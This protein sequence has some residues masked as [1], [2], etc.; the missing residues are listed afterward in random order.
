MNSA[1]IKWLLLAHENRS[2]ACSPPR[3]EARGDT[4]GAGGQRSS[5]GKAAET[6]EEPEEECDEENRDGDSLSKAAAPPMESWD[7]AA[8]DEVAIRVATAVSEQLRRDF[9][10]AVQA[11]LASFRRR[12]CI[13]RCPRR[14]DS[15]RANAAVSSARGSSSSSSSRRVAQRP[16]DPTENG[17]ADPSEEGGGRLPEEHRPGAVE[18]GHGSAHEEA[19]RGAASNDYAPPN[20]GGTTTALLS[21]SQAAPCHI[22]LEAS[23][24]ISRAVRLAELEASSCSGVGMR[25]PTQSVEV[26]SSGEVSISVSAA[27]VSVVVERKPNLN[28]RALPDRADTPAVPLPDLA[29]QPVERGG[30][31]PKFVRPGNSGLGAAP[32]PQGQEQQ[33]EQEPAHPSSLPAGTRASIATRRSLSDGPWPAEEGQRPVG[34]DAAAG[35]AGSAGWS[36]AQS[37]RGP[38]PW[39]QAEGQGATVLHQALARSGSADENPLKSS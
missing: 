36:P 37:A 16:A 4:G 23:S 33:Q 9:R 34:E 15:G 38:D 8:R 17:C 30:R 20:S 26:C 21:A 6:K 32:P 19:C 5:R 10:P 3:N 11:A 29:Q 1:A 27:L 31:A 24:C 22:E 39:L 7:E 28:R 35:S 25:H 2:R 13:W 12:R 18:H 14:S